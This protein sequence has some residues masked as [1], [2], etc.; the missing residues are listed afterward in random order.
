MKVKERKYGMEECNECEVE[1][2]D[3]TI[4]YGSV[5]LCIFW[6]DMDIDRACS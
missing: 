6:V 3:A 4:G 2:K 5:R 1:W